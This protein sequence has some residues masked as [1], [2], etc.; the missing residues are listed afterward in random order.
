[1]EDSALALSTV[2]CCS[3]IS[4]T[5]FTCQGL[6]HGG[7]SWNPMTRGELGGIEQ[8]DHRLMSIWFTHADSRDETGEQKAHWEVSKSMRPSY[9]NAA[10]WAAIYTAHDL[11]G[12]LKVEVVNN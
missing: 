2:F 1:M 8:D 3:A 5:G 10:N 6:P 12:S 7:S 11:L 9:G 4:T